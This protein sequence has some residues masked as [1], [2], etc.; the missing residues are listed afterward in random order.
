LN[1]E[2]CRKTA[3]SLGNLCFSSKTLAEISIK[4]I[5]IPTAND[6]STFVGIATLMIFLD[7]SFYFPHIKMGK[8]WIQNK[9][10]IFF[11]HISTFYA[12]LYI[13]KMFGAKKNSCHMPP[14]TPLTEI[15]TTPFP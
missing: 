2:L 11:L 5:Y 8:Y 7:L 6:I 13:K 9:I 15:C 3:Q 14:P 4:L 12:I 1:I 10:K